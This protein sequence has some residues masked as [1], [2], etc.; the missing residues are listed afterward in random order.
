MQT[1]PASKQTIARKIRK[2]AWRA[3]DL[4]FP[5][6]CLACGGPVT[7]D[8]LAHVCPE[9]EQAIFL[10]KPPACQVCGYPFFG[11]LSGPQQCPHCTEL[12]PVYRSGKTLFLLRSGPGRE[13]IHQLKYQQGFYV[14]RDLAKLV[15]RRPEFLD[16]IRGKQLV[17]VPLHPLKQ[18]ERGYNQSAKIADMLAETAGGGTEVVPLLQRVRW[19]ETQ[20]RFSRAERHENVKNAFAIAPG[21][22][23]DIR[24]PYVVID[25]V[26][27]TGSTL[28]ACCQTLISAGAQQVEVATIGHG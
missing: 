24:K 5:R 18:R 4:L 19:T 6:W 17:P 12:E 16:F 25:D 14:L 13:M 11:V 20:T 15:M 7:G 27:T 22:V 10:V 3:T 21:V 2:V 8:H 28:N 1:P 9:C 26:F 23:L